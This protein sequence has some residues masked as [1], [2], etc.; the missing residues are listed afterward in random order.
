MSLALSGASREGLEQSIFA[1]RS[2]IAYYLPFRLGTE[3]RG[4]GNRVSS[5]TTAD[6]EVRFRLRHC[7]PTV[8]FLFLFL[9]QARKTHRAD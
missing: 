1:G 7:L 8:G 5:I 2:R 9:A 3:D 6:P 4:S